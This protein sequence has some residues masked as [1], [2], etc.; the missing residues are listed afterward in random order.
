MKAT[1]DRLEA[2]LISTLLQSYSNYTVSI[3]R[4]SVS[5][6]VE[7]PYLPCKYVVDWEEYFNPHDNYCKSSHET[8]VFDKAEEAAK[9]FV[10]LCGMVYNCGKPKK[11]GYF[12]LGDKKYG[13]KNSWTPKN[14]KDGED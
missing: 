4:V 2:G 10:E 9:C 14:D 6:E 7:N 12:L 5:A 3:G 8:L 1:I 11:D 13:F